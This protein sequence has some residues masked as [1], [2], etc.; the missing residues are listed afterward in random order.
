MAPFPPSYGNQYI[1]VV[2]DYVSKLVEAVSTP[3]CD[4]KVVM[5]MFQKILF[6]WFGVPRT[7]ISD[8]GPH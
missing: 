3:T 8:E 4:A 1:L 6:P 2:V 7:V 5:K